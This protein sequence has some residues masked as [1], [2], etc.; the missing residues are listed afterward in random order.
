MPRGCVGQ[1]DS[2]PQRGAVRPPDD[3]I[4]L[5]GS[6]SS[7]ARDWLKS[8]AEA[9]VALER[10]VALVEVR[11]ERAL[12]M[13]GSACDAPHIGTASTNVSEE[14]LLA[15]VESEEDLATTYAWATAEL[16]AFDKMAEANR[17]C[18][19]GAVL[20]GLDIAEMKYRIGATDREIM[21]VFYTSRSKL[22]H[23]L[24]AFV[25]YLD[26]IGRERAMHTKKK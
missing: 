2:A 11:R 4:D 3:G 20:E 18:L 25:D 26:F 15:L 6:Q 22:H 7:W 14:N 1:T 10:A 19:R 24:A 16:R 8:V 5:M 9:R 23:D 17:R 12:C 21:R 13:G